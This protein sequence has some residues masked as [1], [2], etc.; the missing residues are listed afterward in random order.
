MCAV[1][2]PASWPPFPS[3]LYPLG[4]GKRKLS[5][6]VRAPRGS[7]PAVTGNAD[8]CRRAPCAGRCKGPAMSKRCVRE[9]L[10][11]RQMASPPPAPFA[12]SALRAAAAARV[13][14]AAQQDSLPTASPRRSWPLLGSSPPPET[15][16]WTLP[17]TSS[18]AHRNTKSSGVRR[19][20][21]S[22]PLQS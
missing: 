4:P 17:G 15:P 2:L 11:A 7:N 8:T 16:A 22:L 20:R 9:D 1:G 13:R 3:P 14:P 6:P 10:H 18:L 12:P 19:P 21:P 5:A